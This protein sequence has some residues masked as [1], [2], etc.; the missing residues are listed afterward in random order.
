MHHPSSDSASSVILTL[1]LQV[2]LVGRL[3]CLHTL[4]RFLFHY[5]LSYNYTHTRCV[6]YLGIAMVCGAAQNSVH[7]Y[8]TEIGS[9]V[10]RSCTQ[11]VHTLHELARNLAPVISAA[12]IQPLQY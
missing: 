6:L 5:T 10:C 2:T 3:L 9:A 11:I 7:S 4:F 1:W 8:G 12:A